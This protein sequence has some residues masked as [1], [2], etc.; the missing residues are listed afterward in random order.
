[1]ASRKTGRSSRRHLSPPPLP[2]SQERGEL[3]RLKRSEAEL[4]AKNKSVSPSPWIS[5]PL[6]RYVVAASPAL[7]FSSLASL[8]LVQ[9]ELEVETLKWRL[10]S[11]RKAKNTTVIRRERETLA[12]SSPRLG[13]RQ[14]SEQTCS[15]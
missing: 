8:T 2:G 13:R 9:L 15:W 4:R 6:P 12:L 11:L 3:E 10:E 7:P 14:P 1:M 5:Q